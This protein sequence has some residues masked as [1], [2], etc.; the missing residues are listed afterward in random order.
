MEGDK[1]SKVLSFEEFMAQEKGEQSGPEGSQETDGA[2]EAPEAGLPGGPEPKEDEDGKMSTNMMD[3][4]EDT[5]DQ[6]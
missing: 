3:A 2:A 5:E 1:N 6:A 4:A